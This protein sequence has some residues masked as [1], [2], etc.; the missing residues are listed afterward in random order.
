MKYK[1]IKYINDKRFTRQSQHIKKSKAS[2]VAQMYRNKGALA[3]IIKETHPEGVLWV[4]Y[5]HG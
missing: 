2:K 3:R 5:T 1:R 4:V